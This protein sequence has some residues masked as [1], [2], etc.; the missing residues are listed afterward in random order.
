MSACHREYWLVAISAVKRQTLNLIDA[1][2]LTQVVSLCG[3]CRA[4]AVRTRSWGTD[5]QTIVAE[6]KTAVGAHIPVPLIKIGEMNDARHSLK[7]LSALGAGHDFHDLRLSLNTK[8]VDVHH[9]QGG[10][11]CATKPVAAIP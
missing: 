1:L 4:P 6:H 2:C 10:V 7:L 5:F 9:C 8:W 3:L 11:L